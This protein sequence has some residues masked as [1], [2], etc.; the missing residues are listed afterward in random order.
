MTVGP[1]DEDL[2]DRARA[3]SAADFGA[4]VAR[5]QA[6]VRSFL[7]RLAAS[8]ADA[9]DLA[10]ETFVAAWSQLGRYRGEA[11]LRT[12]LCGIA[13]KKA[14]GEARSSGR[15]RVRETASAEGDVGDL[16]DPGLR[17]DLGRAMQ[18]LSLDQRAAVALCLGAGFS[19]TEA[20]TALGQPLGTI[21]SHLDRGRVKLMAY[22]GVDHG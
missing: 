2:V 20:A 19:H 9:D 12:W 14:L 1:T 17:L 5:H 13:W 4:I 11:G 18:V 16:T 22:L 21:K 8:E 7:R 10:Q 6:A 15:R 3:G